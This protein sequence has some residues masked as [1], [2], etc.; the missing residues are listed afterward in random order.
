VPRHPTD[1][2]SDAALTS[3]S[4]RHT[5]RASHQWTRRRVLTY[6]LVTA[7]TAVT[8][9]AIGVELIFRD[10]LPGKELL[11]QLDGAC[12]V[13][14]LGTTF[15][16]LGYEMSG[17]FYSHA[18]NRAVGYTIAYPPGHHPGDALA[19]VVTLHAYGG[20]HSNALE[21]MS[22]AQALA[23]R[24][25]N[26][27]LAPVAMVT[28]DGGDGYWNPHPGDDPMAMVSEELI[29]MCQGLALGRPPQRIATMG[30]S[31]GGYGALLLAEKY[32]TLISAVAAISPAIWTS[33]SQAR[34]AN[35]GAYASPADF[36]TCD[37]VTHTAALTDTAVRIVMGT[38]DPFHPGFV[39]LTRALPPHA[40]VV[41]TH[42]CHIGP[43]FKSQQAP[44]LQFL[45]YHL[46]A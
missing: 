2:P 25:D 24:I 44:S 11:E 46:T 38:D 15:A 32:P 9:G 17:T 19:L 33:Y 16:P 1:A 27:L 10:V 40:V 21:A 23:M 43:F 28:V 7:A 18:R 6:G 12:S 20:N 31:M 34:H 3:E 4:R 42:G 29:P 22:P 8:A 5:E 37:A 35:P 13:T 36:A 14:S 39:A 45:A 30:I 41:S 26:S